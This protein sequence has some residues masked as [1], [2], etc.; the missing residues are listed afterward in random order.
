[1]SGASPKVCIASWEPDLYTDST[2][3][4]LLIFPMPPTAS[5][6]CFLFDTDLFS[7]DDAMICVQR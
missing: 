5:A 2:E 4:E 6:D 3:V 1:M 7:D